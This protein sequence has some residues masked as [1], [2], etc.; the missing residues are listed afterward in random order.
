MAIL[1]G[2]DGT[3]YKGGTPLVPLSAW[4]LALKC[5][6]YAYSTNDSGGAMRRVA[7]ATDC[8]GRLRIALAEGQSCPLAPGQ[9]VALQL[10]VDAT[11]QNYYELPAVIER[12]ELAVELS[13]GEPLAYEA[14]F[15]ANGPLVA[16]G[17]LQS[18]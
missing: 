18:T 8:K 1:S 4:R 5:E 13:S 12:V 15:A 6:T 16:H 11:G 3:V 2:K 10:H 7:G 9:S 14:A 17:S